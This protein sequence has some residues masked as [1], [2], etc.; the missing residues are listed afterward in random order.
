MQAAGGDLSASAGSE[1]IVIGTSVLTS[2]AEAGLA[3]LADVV[4][5]ATFPDSEVELAKRNAA[6]HLQQQESD[7]SFLAERAL[8]RVLF[9]QHP[10]AVTSLTQDSIAKATPQELRSEYAR[11]FRPDQ[12]ILVVVGDFDAAKMAASTESLLGK[13]AAPSTSPGAGG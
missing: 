12:A 9:A 11:R 13:W 2:K 8:A 5:N 10:Y 3:V 1:S 4:R 6:D 7:P